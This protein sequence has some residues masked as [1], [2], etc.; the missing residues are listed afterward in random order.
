MKFLNALFVAFSFAVALA[1]HADVAIEPGAVVL[2]NI[3]GLAEGAPSRIA[4][5]CMYES[6]MK[7][8]LPQAWAEH[9]SSTTITTI[10][11]QAKESKDSY[12]GS[13]LPPKLLLPEL[14]SKTTYLEWTEPTT[15]VQRFVDFD[16]STL[17]EYSDE[18]QSMTVAVRTNAEGPQMEINL[19]YSAAYLPRIEILE[20]VTEVC[21]N[22]NW[23]RHNCTK[24]RNLLSATLKI[25]SKFVNTGVWENEDTWIATRKKFDFKDYADCIVYSFENP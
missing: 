25:P 16:F 7:S 18:S 23:G 14:K 1:A 17:G 3:S 13:A 22:N 6:T 5:Q 21:T 4:N 11:G 12:S 19:S 15:S 9:A 20:N 2:L 10:T 24:T 8:L